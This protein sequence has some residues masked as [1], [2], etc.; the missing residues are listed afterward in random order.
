YA[1]L[2]AEGLAAPDAIKAFVT[3][4]RAF[5]LA[6]LATVRAGWAVAQPPDVFVV[7]SNLFFLSGTAPLSVHTI[8]LNSNAF[9]VTWTTVSNWMVALA[10]KSGTNQF[11]IQGRD[12]FGRIVPGASSLVTVVFNGVLEPIE[13]NLVF[14]EIL[15]ALDVLDTEFMEI[16]NLSATSAY[17]LGY[18]AVEGRPLDPLLAQEVEPVSYSFPLG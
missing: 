17:D 14:N 8:T 9:S 1:V 12:R 13:S 3:Q 16:H 11:L 18:G 2:A 10:L 4:R 5:L 15:D 6:Q 7:S